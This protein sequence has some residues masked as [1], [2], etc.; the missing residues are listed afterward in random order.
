[1]AVAEVVPAGSVPEHPQVRHNGSVVERVDPN[2]GRMRVPRHA[3]RFGSTPA[4]SPG[5]VPAH[6]QHTAE[7]LRELGLSEREID[8]LAR[9]GVAGVAGTAGATGVGSTP[10]VRSAPA[11]PLVGEGAVD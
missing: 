9:A 6:G 4:E 11:R 1:V 3:A 2:V 7:V 8:E 10:G 5:D